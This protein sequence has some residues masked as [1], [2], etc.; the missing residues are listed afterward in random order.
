MP[1]TTSV[2][3]VTKV[4]VGGLVASVE[5]CEDGREFV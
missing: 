3:M 2:T 4:D 1:L 5:V